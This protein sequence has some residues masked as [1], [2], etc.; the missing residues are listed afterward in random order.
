MGI[1]SSNQTDHDDHKNNSNNNNDNIN[2]SSSNFR[3]PEVYEFRFFI[4]FYLYCY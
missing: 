2:N 4:D 1:H 3:R